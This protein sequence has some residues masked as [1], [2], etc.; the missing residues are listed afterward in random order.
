MASALDFDAAIRDDIYYRFRTFYPDAAA[1]R[2]RRLGN[3]NYI[4]WTGYLSL[5]LCL[6]IKTISKEKA[7]VQPRNY[8][9][10]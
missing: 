7:P 5:F 2:S 1:T 3:S 6:R 9:F 4:F 10:N 8:F